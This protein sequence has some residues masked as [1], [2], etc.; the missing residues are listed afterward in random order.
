MHMLFGSRSL[1]RRHSIERRN[2]IRHSLNGHGKTALI[3]G[4]SSG[5]GY[6]LTKRFARDGC[7]LVLVARNAPQLTQVA[8]E[9]RRSAQLL[10]GDTEA[11]TWNPH[12]SEATGAT[13]ASAC[14]RGPGGCAVV[15]RHAL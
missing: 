3:T 2:T 13:T 12:R 9:L 14:V 8:E 15:E 5:I 11:P 4:A 7:T 10:T 1:S 6:E